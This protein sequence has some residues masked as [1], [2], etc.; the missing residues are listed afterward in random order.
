LLSDP[1]STG[2]ALYVRSG[3]GAGEFRLVVE[4]GIRALS[5]GIVD[6]RLQ[7]C[8]PTQRRETN[9]IVV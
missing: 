6:A 8:Q 9:G 3:Q 5:H 4:E 7:V 1:L 2:E